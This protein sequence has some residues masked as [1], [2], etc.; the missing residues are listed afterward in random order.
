MWVDQ[1]NNAWGS[2][3]RKGGHNT[4]DHLCINMGTRAFEDI[5][6]KNEQNKESDSFAFRL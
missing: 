5:N 3:E 1:S 4:N 6:T 2:A